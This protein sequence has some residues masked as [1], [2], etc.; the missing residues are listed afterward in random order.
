MVEHDALHLE[1]SLYIALQACERLNLPSGFSIPDFE[2]L[3][4]GWNETV[5]F[6]GEKRMSRLEFE[7]QEVTL[8]HEDNDADLEE[9]DEKHELGWDPERTFI[10]PSPV[11]SPFLAHER[12]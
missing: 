10:P 6:E 8:G 5:R 9:Y 7:A 12:G 3:A 11:S 1:T 2:S 4:R